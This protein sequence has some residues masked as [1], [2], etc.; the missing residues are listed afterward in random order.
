MPVRLE[1]VPV[2]VHLHQRHGL[3]TLP[4][5]LANLVSKHGTKY[6]MVFAGMTMAAVPMIV[7]FFAAQRFFVRGL[8]EGIGK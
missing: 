1:R 7:F 4:V 6:P 8:S 2:R 5:G 3:E